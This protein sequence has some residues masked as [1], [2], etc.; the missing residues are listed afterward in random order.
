MERG[1]STKGTIMQILAIFAASDRTK[2]L[3]SILTP[4]LVIHGDSDGLVH[5]DGGVATS[6]AI[7]NAKLKI[8]KGMGHDFPVELI[9]SIIS[10]I[11]EHVTVESSEI[12]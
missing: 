9:P 10:D 4:T 5:C 12:K 1:M 8:Y 6:N 7:K 2:L 11:V 3:N